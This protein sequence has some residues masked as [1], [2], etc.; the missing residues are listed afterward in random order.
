MAKVVQ[1][2]RAGNNARWILDA[3]QA[4]ERRK[5]PT[6]VL[7]KVNLQLPEVVL[8]QAAFDEMAAVAMRAEVWFRLDR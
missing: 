7:A 4:G 3:L 2:Q 8:A 1:A 5:V 6:A